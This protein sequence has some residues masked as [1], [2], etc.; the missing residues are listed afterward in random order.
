MACCLGGGSASDD[1]DPELK[2]K[3]SDVKKATKAAAGEDA[4]VIKML[5]LGAGESGKSTIFKQMKIINKDGYSKEERL[6]FRSIIW[7][8]TIVSM[9]LLAGAFDKI[10]DEEEDPVVKEMLDRLE[11]A[12]EEEESLTN[13]VEGGGNVGDLIKKMWGNDKIRFYFE[14]K[15]KFQ[16]NDSAEYYFDALDRL[17]AE[18][19]EPTEQDVL[20]SRVRT[21]GI[22]QSDFVIKG[23]KFSMF[24][25][26]GQRNERRKWIHCFDNVDAVVFVAALSEFDQVLYEDESQNRMCEAL[27][28]FKQIAN[29]KWFADT[30]MILFLNKKDLFEQ[31]LAKMTVRRELMSQHCTVEKGFKEAYTGSNDFEDC[32]EFWKRQ[33]CAQSQNEEKSIYIHATCATDTSNVKFVF[34]AVVSIILEANMKASGLV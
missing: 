18:S 7:S 26:G 12:T 6:A 32:V 19:Y 13:E 23:T 24:D 3:N 29:S 17:S 1:V 9:K 20:R 8:N 2:R 27:D 11:D 33:F 14:N 5:L 31:K 10:P 21:T 34:D 30:S 16:L 22:V 4:K 28:L 15:S 25:V